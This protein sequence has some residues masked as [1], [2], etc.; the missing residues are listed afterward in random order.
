MPYEFDTS[1]FNEHSAG[2]TKAAFTQ[3]VAKLDGVQVLSR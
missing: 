1:Q 3:Q 2:I